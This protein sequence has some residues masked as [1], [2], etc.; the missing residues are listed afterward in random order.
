MIGSRSISLILVASLGLPG[1]AVP[2]AYAEPSSASASSVRE[3]GKHFQRGVSLYTEAD[4]RAALVEFRRAYEIAP[5]SAVLYNIGET[6]Y[7]LQNY[8][9]ALSTL[10]RYLSE[11]GATAGHRREVEQTIDTL[12]TR[13]GKVA[14]ATNV[15]DCEITVDDELVGRTP[16]TEPL[17]VSIGRRKI[18]AM[19][20]GRAPETR[21]VD[22]AA[23]DTVQLALSLGDGAGRA[24]AGALSTSTATPPRGSDGKGLITAGWVTTGV[25]G[26]GAL[27]TGV[28]A[29]LASRQLSDLRNSYPTSQAELN[30]KGSRVSTLS[31]VADILGVA[32]LV[33][34]GLTLTLSLSRSHDHEVHVAL[35]PNGLQLAGTF[36]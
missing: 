22:V 6:Y 20:E 15:P 34:G 28:L 16:L 25:L 24:P 31:T 36:R 21:F 23:G 11:S 4:Y 19:R 33:T 1:I 5:N 7:Q 27:T 17:L 9:A 13:V 18:T 26:A 30:S 3:A 8:A 32:A 14:I 29:F 12:Q 2:A 35:A 10:Q